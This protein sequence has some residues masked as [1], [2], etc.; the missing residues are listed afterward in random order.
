MDTLVLDELEDVLL[1][2]LVV[3]DVDE[4]VVVVVDTLDLDELD[5]VVLEL[6]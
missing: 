4:G 3:T 5:D 1:D 6:W 2:T